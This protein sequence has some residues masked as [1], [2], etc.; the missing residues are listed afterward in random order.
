MPSYVNTSTTIG[1]TS[2]TE[3][4]ASSETPCG[5][6]RDAVDQSQ[7]SGKLRL[8]KNAVIYVRVSTREQE[9]EGLS[10]PAQLR[11]LRDYAE[12]EAFI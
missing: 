3:V 8:M 7:L 5:D 9:R 11:I 6:S 4:L 10:I 12:S 1:I 2:E